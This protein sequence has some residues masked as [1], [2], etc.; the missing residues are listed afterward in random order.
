MKKNVWDEHVRASLSTSDR[1]LGWAWFIGVPEGRNHY[2]QLCMAANREDREDW[3]SFT[4]KSADII[5]P[6]ELLAVKREMDPVV[7]A[8]EYE[9]SFVNFMGRAY[10]QFDSE[11]NAVARFEYDPTLPLIFCFDFNVAP[12][13]CAIAID[14]KLLS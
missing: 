11:K 3:A 10:Y 9:G 8:Q 6:Q 4:W 7:F 13:V 5:H 14:Q 1:P 12:G 2:Y